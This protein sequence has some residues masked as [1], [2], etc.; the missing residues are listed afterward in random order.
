MC[1]G[2]ISGIL[3]GKTAQKDEVGLLMTKSHHENTE[4]EVKEDGSSE[5]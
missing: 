3:D 2:K 1:G 5:A 4:M